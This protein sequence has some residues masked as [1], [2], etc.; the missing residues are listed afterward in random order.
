MAATFL[1][2]LLAFAVIASLSVG[3]RAIPPSEI[4]G[5]LFGGLDSD[6]A[7]VITSQRVPRTLLGLA[8]GACLGLGGALMQGH[9]RN[10]L[11][12]P[13]LFGVN[14]GASLGVA[15][16]VFTVGTVSSTAIVIAALVGAGVAATIVFAF[17]LRDISSSALVMLA[18]VGTTLAALLSAITSMLVLMDA[19]TLDV[20]RF[21]DVGS[22]VRRN[23]DLAGLLA[24]LMAVGALLALQSAFSLNALGLGADVATTLGSRVALSRVIS[25]IAITL[26]AGSATALCGPISFLGLVAP[27]LARA[28]A[29]HDYR[30][31]VPFAGIVGATLILAADTLGRVSIPN[32]ELQVGIVLAV[33]GGPGLLIIARRRRVVAL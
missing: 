28:L 27:H 26:L 30:K 17:G 15:I 2:V 21:W 12:D 13:G 32:G 16:T 4:I 14:A 5:A 10:P 6:N 7:T 20:L 9:T 33:I 25:I 3:S 23:L 22:L 31:I 18:V 19:S 11:A 8:T 24:V 1:L 29:G